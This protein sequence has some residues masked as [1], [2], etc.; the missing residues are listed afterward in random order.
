V[1][2][3]VGDTEIQADL[4]QEIGFGQD[5]AFG[6]EIG[7]HIKHQAVRALAPAVLVV[8]QAIGIAAVGVQSESS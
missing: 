2:V 7:R 6:L 3:F 5:H 4:V 1:L 8:Q